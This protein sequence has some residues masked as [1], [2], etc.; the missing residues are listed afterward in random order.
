MSPSPTRD[1]DIPLTAKPDRPAGSPIGGAPA[2]GAGPFGGGGGSAAAAALDPMATA[3]L[4][5][6]ILSLLLMC[7]CGIATFVFGPAAVGLG[8]WALVRIKADPE[9]LAGAGM[10]YAGIGL[11]AGTLVLY[12]ILLVFSVGVNLLGALLS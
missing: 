4:V 9:H 10:A 1:G 7:C 6:G 2:G 8:A 5:C 3:S 12:V 11:G